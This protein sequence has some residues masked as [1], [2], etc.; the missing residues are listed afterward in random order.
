MESLKRQ[1]QEKMNRRLTN[2]IRF[3]M[4]ELIPPVIRDS[5]VFMYPFFVFAYRGR[6]I[7]EVMDFKKNVYSYSPDEYAAFY[8]NLNT[9]SRNRATD[10]NPACIQ[11]V[12]DQLDEGDQT[13]VDIGCGKGFMLRQIASRNPKL[14][15][16]GFDI[17]EPEG[18]EPFNYVLGNVEALPFEDRSFDVVL[19]NHTIEHLLQ[20]DQCIAELIRIT[21]RKLIVVTP[22]QRYYYYT[23]DEHVNFFPFKESLTSRFMLEDHVCYKLQGDWVYM[24]NCEGLIPFDKIA[25]ETSLP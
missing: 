20:L 23:L 5:R 12:L 1:L 7:S 16:T 21:R 14:E 3:V 18:N 13:V 6:N 17:K 25:N 19:C 15:L 4:D 8:N 24:A 2:A 10:L 11:F 22:C 9:I